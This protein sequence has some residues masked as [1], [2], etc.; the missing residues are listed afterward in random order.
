MRSNMAKIRI[1]I[2]VVCEEHYT[3]LEKKS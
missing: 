1:F 2:G 3:A